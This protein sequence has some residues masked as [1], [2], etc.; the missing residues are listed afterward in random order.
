MIMLKEASSSRLLTYAAIESRT[1]NFVNGKLDSSDKPPVVQVK[2]LNN[3]RIVGS[4]AQKY[5]LFRLF[6][7]IFWD[8]VEYLKSFKIYLILREL[9][10]MVLALP[11]RKSWLPFMETL[12][13]SFQSMMLDFNPDKLIPKVHFVTE[14]PK[15]SEENGPPIKYWCMR[16]GD[17]HL[18]FKR[19]AMEAYNFKNIPK[20]LAQRQQLRQCFLLSKY[21]F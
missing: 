18:Y 12:S 21:Q 13:I 17:A 16:Y 3:D 14:Y 1:E 9:L 4:A 5:C 2:H 10:D 7:I 11:Q 19:I 15:L 20:T 8:I 6:P